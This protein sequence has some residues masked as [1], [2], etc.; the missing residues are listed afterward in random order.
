MD[1]F[2]LVWWFM[3]CIYCFLLIVVQGA[4]SPTA[5]CVQC[6]C[7]VLL[8]YYF[9]LNPNWTRTRKEGKGERNLKL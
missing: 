6:S 7:L 1:G 9:G 3:G 8:Y 5:L 4:Y 2:G